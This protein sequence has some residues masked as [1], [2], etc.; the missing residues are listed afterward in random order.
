L[1]EL[2]QDYHIWCVTHSLELLQTYIWMLRWSCIF[3]LWDGRR[4]D[5]V[6]VSLKM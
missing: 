3:L 4:E 2:D 5:S 1:E 6:T